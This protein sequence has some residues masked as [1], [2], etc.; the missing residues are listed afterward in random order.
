[1]NKRFLNAQELLEDSFRLGSEIY[2]SGFRPDCIVGIWRGGTPVGIAIHE[3]FDYMGVKTDH[4]P[5]KVSSYTGINEQ[6]ETVTITGLDYILD[7]TRETDRI[8]LVDDVFDSGNT[9][10]EI[11]NQLEPRYGDAFHDQV[12]IACPWYKP[13]NNRTDL[14][15]DYYLHET[16]EWLVFP[17]EI[18]GLSD[19][20]LQQG[21][22]E[23]SRILAA[24][25][26]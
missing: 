10:K 21:K 16:A 22:P 9:M 2:R 23:I 15:P 4:I 3:F 5:I 6:S 13:D 11:Y 14:C 17:H 7:N 26:N 25:K 18:A 8:L 19:A 20:E 24:C 1:M 12:K